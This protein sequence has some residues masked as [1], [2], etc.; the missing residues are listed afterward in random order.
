MTKLFIVA[1]GVSVCTKINYK[2]KE[3]FSPHYAACI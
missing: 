1:G 3:I 2:E